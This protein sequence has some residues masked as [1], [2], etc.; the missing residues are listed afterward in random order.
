[1]RQIKDTAIN[2]SQ[3]SQ[4][5]YVGNLAYDVEWGQVKG[6]S[7]SFSIGK[8]PANLSTKTKEISTVSSRLLRTEYSKILEIGEL[9][10][11]E[12]LV[13]KEPEIR[14]FYLHSFILKFCSPY[15]RDK[16]LS[17]QVKFENNI[18]KFRKPNTAVKIFD[19]LI[20]IYIFDELELEN[21]SIIINV[22]FLITADELCFSDL[23]NFIEKYLLKDEELLK[24]NFILIQNV[25][26][27]HSK[28]KKLSQFY[29]DTFEQ[30][31]SLIFKASDFTSIKKENLLVILSKKNH[32]L[33]PIEVW[34]KLLEWAIGQTDELPSDI[35]K[36]TANNIL[37]CKTLIR[38]FIP[39]VNFIEIDSC[40]FFLKIKPLKDLFDDKVYIKIL[41]NY[42]F[43]NI[44][45]G[46]KIIDF[47]LV[48]L[49]VKLIKYIENMNFM[50]FIMANVNL[51]KFKLLVR[52]SEN[53]FDCKSFHKYCDNKGPTITIAKVKMKFL[54]DLF[55]AIGNLRDI[56]IL[57]NQVLS[58]L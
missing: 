26:K 47:N 28:F 56:V 46:S 29:K 7:S 13:G 44:D 27:Y 57:L 20:N 10:D 48:C 41:E 25:A 19:I 45:I 31:P 50:E 37:T 32:S 6:P 23:C 30:D 36:W 39:Y 8:T 9:H 52:G 18:Y 5:E 33:K 22:V 3:R 12:I 51:Y 53:G 38:K 24:K 21:N 42:S 35:T 11:T 17:D 16:L 49:L 2:A 34:G 55:H 14:T 58:F 43:N 40:S 54:E 4:K 1:M 15:F